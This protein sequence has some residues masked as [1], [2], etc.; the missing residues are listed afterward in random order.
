MD[1]N[2]FASITQRVIDRDGFDGFQPSACFPERR[3]LRVL[4]ELPEDIEVEP[5]VI[6]WA[7]QYARPNEEFLVAFKSGPLEFTV[8][9]QKGRKKESAKFQVNVRAA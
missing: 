8:I 4:A 7:E 5:A 2:D 9:R 1:I 3:E 6:E